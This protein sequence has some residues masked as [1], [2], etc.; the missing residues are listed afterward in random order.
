MCAAIETVKALQAE[1][2]CR[3]L[4]LSSAP[5]AVQPVETPVVLHAQLEDSSLTDDHQVSQFGI[6][7]LSKTATAIY[8]F[9][10]S[11]GRQV[12]FNFGRLL[13]VLLL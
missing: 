3:E 9:H 12:C 2:R 8:C 13:Y 5:S 6:N 11:K 4:P 7:Q 1:D 10:L